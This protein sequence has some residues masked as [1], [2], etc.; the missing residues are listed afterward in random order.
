MNQS[1]NNYS[2]TINQNMYNTNPMNSQTD[3]NQKMNQNGMSQNEY[4]QIQ[5]NFN[6][7]NYSNLI[8][9]IKLNIKIILK[10]I[11]K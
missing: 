7:T 4:N 3:Y 8:N 10:K 1:N 9:F 6:Q 2:Q 5:N 11:I